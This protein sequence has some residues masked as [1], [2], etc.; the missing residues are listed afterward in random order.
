[1]VTDK[2]YSEIDIARQLPTY[3]PAAT[4][5]WSVVTFGFLGFAVAAGGYVLMEVFGGGAESAVQAQA[6]AQLQHD[7]RVVA[8]IGTG[9]KAMNLGGRRQANTVSSEVTGEDG[10]KRI[11]VNVALVVKFISTRL[12]IFHQGLSR[13]NENDGRLNDFNVYA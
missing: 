3:G 4:A 6:V 10:R 9:A 12:I 1:M 5:G 11:Q 7:P 2:V 8:L 13:Q